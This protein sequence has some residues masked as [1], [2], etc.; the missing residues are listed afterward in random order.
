MTTL[1]ELQKRASRTAYARGMNASVRAKVFSQQIA[2]A[3]NGGREE[4]REELRGIRVT[5]D[6]LL[7]DLRDD[8]ISLGPFLDALANLAWD[9]EH[10]QTAAAEPGTVVLSSPDVPED[11]P[12]GL[13]H[14]IHE[15]VM[16]KTG[17]R[18][19]GPSYELDG[20]PVAVPR[21]YRVAGAFG[22]SYD[23]RLPAGA[24][25]ID[26]GG[27]PLMGP[28]WSPSPSPEGEGAAPMARETRGGPACPDG[29]TCHHE[30]MFACFRVQCCGPLSGT[31]PD[32]AWPAA[33]RRKYGGAG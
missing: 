25:P 33:V 11:A 7:A 32:D 8:L 14:Q 12:L 18:P 10:P 27:D 28:P 9:H 15:E 17:G 6:G 16:E 5:I 29:G 3:W 2:E 22:W 1:E 21:Y 26:F 24:V 30:C 19:G 13:L 31:Y 4:A 20:A 23:G